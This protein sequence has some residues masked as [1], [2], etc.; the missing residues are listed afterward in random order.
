MI[1]PITNLIY[2]QIIESIEKDKRLDNRNLN[3]YRNLKLEQ[4]IIESAEGSARVILGKT[5][6]V[7]GIKVE[8]GSPF[9]DTP[10]LGVMTVNAELTP[11]ASQE[12]ETGPPGEEA[13]ELAR[14]VDRGIRESKTI[15]LEKLCI[16]V[17]KKVF[18]VSP[19]VLLVSRILTSSEGTGSL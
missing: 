6:V 16:E 7:V 19:S 11:L 14:I 15:D 5:E 8:I 1:S 18:V 9:P 2:K 13:I 17:G 4:G 12:F 3:D 10:N